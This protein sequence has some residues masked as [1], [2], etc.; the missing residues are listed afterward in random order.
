VTGS[1][2]PDGRQ[3]WQSGPPAPRYDHRGTPLPTDDHAWWQL[4]DDPAVVKSRPRRRRRMA[5]IIGGVALAALVIV[6]GV[7][8]FV[9]SPSPPSDSAGH[10]AA[11][12]S[13]ATPTSHRPDPQQQLT[14]LVP[15]GYPLGSCVVTRPN[16]GTAAAVTC[17]HNT[18][19]DGPTTATYAV[20]SDPTTL[21]RAFDAA[22]A[23]SPAVICP[24]NI[25]S[26]GPWR[27]NA[28]P[29]QI[30]G[31]LVCGM[32]GDV[33]TVAWTNDRNLLLGIVSGDPRGPDLAGL[34]RWWAS[35]S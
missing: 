35:H 33:P 17:G 10:A 29:D 7:V 12:G 27:R 20:A 19:P 13:S 15:P 1:P 16:A 34:Y 3:T 18:D 23:D 28:T 31:T 5:L 6:I 9:R 8:V 26:P 2:P 22:V 24:G 11:G 21:R 30:S 32:R 14:P 25:Q 4:F